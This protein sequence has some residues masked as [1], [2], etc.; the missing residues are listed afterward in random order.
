MNIIL[1]DDDEWRNFRP[2]SLTKPFAE[3]R[4]GVLSFR[5]R[6]EKLISGNFSYLTINHLSDKYKI[7]ISNQNLFINPAYFPTKNLTETIRELKGGE[8]IWIG[9]RM[10]AGKLMYE[11]FEDREN[12]EGRTQIQGET[13]H[14]N[15]LWDLFTYNDY[16]IRFDFELLTQ[17][18]KSQPISATNGVKNPENIFLE[19]GAIVEFAL[20]NASSGPIYIGKNAEI[21]EGSMVRGSFALGESAKLNM[22]AKIYPGTS[23]G[24]Y[25]KAGGELNNSILMGYSNKGHDG[26]LGNS[27]IGEWCNL[28]ADT[29]TSNLKNNYSEIRVWDYETRNYI[30]SG[31]QFCGL[32]MGDYSKS[33]INTQFNTGTVVGVSANVFD[34]GFPPKFIPSF[35]WGGG[36]D[37]GKFALEKSYEAI[38]KMMERRQKQLTD[39][40]KKI[41]S[42]I[43]QL[44]EY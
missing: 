24:P 32:V 11:D 9:N 17:G 13:I 10:I 40:E 6:W 19:E 7:N 41:I 33:A 27:V 3:L 4:I 2:L 12:K 23:I 14:L 44:T 28:G 42:H 25:C 37:S 29:N 16:A 39:A 38:E 43:F 30:D 36:K 20:L 21:M 31:L 18:R 5:E 26:F 8:S 35:S 1:F 22:G 15:R 34:A